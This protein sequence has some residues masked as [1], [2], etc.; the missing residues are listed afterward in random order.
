M[1]FFKHCRF[2]VK[3]TEPLQPS[4]P[5]D[6]VGSGEAGQPIGC[7]ICRFLSAPLCTRAVPLTAASI[8]AD[9][10]L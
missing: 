10:R 9:V 3:G 2:P 1:F 5:I 4:G 7:L 8:T 6:G